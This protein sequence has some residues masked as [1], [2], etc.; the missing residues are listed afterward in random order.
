MAQLKTTRI[1]ATS[2]ASVKIRDSYYT[3]EYTEERV[4]PEEFKGS[5]D[6][7]RDELWELCNSEVDRQI[8]DAIKM[9]K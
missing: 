6:D 8:E 5:L 9:L 4:V 2:R 1:V 3:F 7:E